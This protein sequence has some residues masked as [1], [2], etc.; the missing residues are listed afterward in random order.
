M[1]SKL[2]IVTMVD[3]CGYD[4]WD[5]SYHL[6]KKGAYRAIIDRNYLNWEECRYINAG[7]YD[8]LHMYVREGV[9][10]E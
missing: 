10:Q 2:Y 3:P 5:V 6:T 8:D 9:L 7:S 4:S 1:S